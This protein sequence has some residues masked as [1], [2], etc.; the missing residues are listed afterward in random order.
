MATAK[1]T[2]AKVDA[3]ENLTTMNPEM[4]KEGYEKIAENMGVF[5]DFQKA[6]MEALMTS[7]GAFAK[8]VE[9]TA[10]ENTAFAKEAVEEG[11][12]AAKAAASSKSIQEAIDVQ[13][14]FVRSTFEKNVSLFN[15]NADRWIAVSKEVSQPLTDQYGAIVEKVQSFRP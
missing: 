13:S 5:V 3:F 8:G 15:K 10:S 2:T 9:Q 4:F 14:E 7:F 6:S 1:K 12:A 11:V